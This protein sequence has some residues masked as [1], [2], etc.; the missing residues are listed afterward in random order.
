MKALG[1]LVC[2]VLSAGV[3]SSAAQAQFGQNPKDSLI[4]KAKL[5]SLN[6]ILVGAKEAKAAVKGD[7]TAQAKKEEQEK[8]TEPPKPRSSILRTL[9]RRTATYAPKNASR[10]KNAEPTNK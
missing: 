6:Q 10:V 1:W 7:T 4:L 8:K 9:E 5:D 2:F 3:C